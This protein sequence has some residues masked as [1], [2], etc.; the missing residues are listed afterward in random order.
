MSGKTA[1]DMDGEVRGF[2]SCLA[3]RVPDKT[4]LS[5]VLTYLNVRASEPYLYGILILETYHEWNAGFLE[6]K[7]VCTHALS[8]TLLVLN[9]LI[10]LLNHTIIFMEL[11]NLKVFYRCLTDYNNFDYGKFILPNNVTQNL[12]T[13]MLWKQWQYTHFQWYRSTNFKR[14]KHGSIPVIIRYNKPKVLC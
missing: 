9:S 5:H 1:S 8:V 11:F 6:T 7:H 10:I 2:L 3:R 14:I 4:A 12:F 13:P